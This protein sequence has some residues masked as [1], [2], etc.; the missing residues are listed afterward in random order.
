MAQSGHKEK[1]S[2]ITIHVEV[3]LLAGGLLTTSL[4]TVEL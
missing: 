1:Q 3:Y 4:V 2:H